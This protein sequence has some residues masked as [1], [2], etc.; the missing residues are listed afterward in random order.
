MIPP[1]SASQV[2]RITSMSHWYLAYPVVLANYFNLLMATLA[3]IL[4][5]NVHFSKGENEAKGLTWAQPVM[6]FPDLGEGRGWQYV[7]HILEHVHTKLK[8]DISI[9]TTLLHEK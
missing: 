4:N 1:S 2:A 6:K 9:I 7:S 3:Q 8:P 5:Y